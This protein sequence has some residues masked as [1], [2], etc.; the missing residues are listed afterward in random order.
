MIGLKLYLG[1]L[2]GGLLLELEL[3]GHLPGA[4]QLGSALA[5][6]GHGAVVQ[7]GL[8]I[9]LLLHN[10]LGC[11]GGHPG[12]LGTSPGQLGLRP[13]ISSV[14]LGH[15]FLVSWGLIWAMVR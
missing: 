7:L 9:S 1:Y 3:G 10:L 12:F 6:L 5:R 13:G 11:V 8:G 14:Q 4:G 15:V 2:Y